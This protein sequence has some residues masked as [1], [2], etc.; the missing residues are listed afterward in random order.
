MILKT[1]RRKEMSEALLDIRVFEGKTTEEA[2]NKANEHY[3]NN[4]PGRFDAF[5][6]EREGNIV[7][8]ILVT[9]RW[10]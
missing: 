1:Y 6:I 7:K 10:E 9:T 2:A 3:S 5:Q 8:L 4:R